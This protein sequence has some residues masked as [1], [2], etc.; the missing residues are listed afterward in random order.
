MEWAIAQGMQ[1]LGEAAVRGKIVELDLS[2]C[3]I[4]ARGAEIIA[5]FL[6]SNDTVVYV[7]LWRCQIGSPGVEA[8]AEA[9]KENRTMEFLAI[10][11]SDIG[12]GEKSAEIIVDALKH[13][14]SL[15]GL[16]IDIDGSHVDAELLARIEY[17]TETRNEILI[18]AAVRRASLLLVGTRRSLPLSGAGMFSMMPK[19]IVKMVAMKVWAS[20]RDPIWIQTLSHSQ[21]TGESGD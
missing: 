20:R 9:L 16:T 6:H 3:P 10:G 15:T 13:N 8:I 2:G 5:N 4:G 7:L 12:T 1:E 19:E 21:Q 14:A 18:P 11:V 17:L